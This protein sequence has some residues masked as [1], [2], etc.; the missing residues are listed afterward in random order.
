MN[1]ETF[2]KPVESFRDINAIRQLYDIHIKD[3]N[4]PDFIY[5]LSIDRDSTQVSRFGDFHRMEDVRFFFRDKNHKIPSH[6]PVIVKNYYLLDKDPCL[7]SIARH[8]QRKDNIDESLLVKMR[9]SYLDRLR[10]EKSF[11]IVSGNEALEI[12]LER[13][14]EY[15]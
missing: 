7:K 15:Q 14:L 6:Y 13:E 4:G 2:L 1:L 12:L 9:E 11:E 10:K 8:F 5:E 3:Y